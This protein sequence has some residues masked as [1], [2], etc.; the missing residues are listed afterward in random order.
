MWLVFNFRTIAEDGTGLI[1]LVLGIIFFIMVIARIKSIH[2]QYERPAI[3]LILFTAI[4]GAFLAIAG[5][6]FNVNQFKWI[7][8]LCV[9]WSC[10]C[11]SLPPNYYRDLLLAFFILYW[12]HPI[13]NR[14]FSPLQL[15]MQWLSVQGAEW[16]LHCFNVRAWANDFILYT[17]VSDFGVPEACSGMKTSVAVLYA[18]LGMGI[19][20]H[21]SLLAIL[22][23]L[24]I[25][26]FQ[27]LVLNIIRIS[28]I[29]FWSQRMPAG[30]GQKFIHDSSGIFLIISIFLIMGEIIWWHVLCKRKKEREEGIASG[31]RE[32]PEVAT[33]LPRMWYLFF[34]YL[35][36]IV[37]LFVVLIFIVFALYKKR[38]EHRA[39]MYSDVVAGLA[40]RDTKM[41]LSAIEAAIKL[42]PDNREFKDKKIQ[43]LLMQGKYAASLKELEKLARPLAP[44]ETVLMSRTL[45]ML[46]RTQEAIEMIKS[47]P[48]D[49]HKQPAVAM[50]MAE[51]GALQNDVQ[52]VCENIMLASSSHLFVDRIRA[53]FP[54][55]Q[56]HEQWQT[57]ADADIFNIPHKNPYSMAIVIRA[58]LK[59]GNFAKAARLLDAAFEKWP[60][61]PQFLGSLFMLALRQPGSRWE[62]KFAE[63]FQKNI[64]LLDR[65][66]L[67]TY[68]QELFRI[69]RPDLVWLAWTRLNKLDPSDPILSLAAARFANIWFSF[70]P[71]FLGLSSMD[72]EIVVDVSS[73]YR[74]TRN[75]RPFSFF[76]RLVP[77]AS[78][79]GK[80]D[81]LN[82]VSK[83]YLDKCLDS[84][85]VYKEK[86]MLTR[87]MEINVPTILAMSGKYD[88]AHRA[89]AE[90]MKKYPDENDELLLKKALL[91]EYQGKWQDCYEVLREYR[92]KSSVPSINTE[93]MMINALMNM[94][95]GASAMT[96][97][98]RAAKHFP[99]SSRIN[100]IIA[101]IWSNFGYW[102]EALF[103]MEKVKSTRKQSL[104]A[105]LLY[106]TQRYVEADKIARSSGIILPK[107]PEEKI[108]SYLP[109]PA[110]LTIARRWP[111]P[112]SDFE[113]KDRAK[114]SMD[115]SL[116][117][118]SPFLKR[119][120]NLECEWQRVEGKGK[121]SDIALWE[122][123]G[124]DDMEK[125][126][127]LNRLTIL[128]ASQ[129]Q[130][131]DAIKTAKRT[132]QLSPQT[133][134]YWWILI[135]LTEGDRAVVE[136]ARRNCPDDGEIW[137]ADI[138]SRYKTE[139]KGKWIDEEIE[140]VIKTECYPLATVVRAGNFLVNQGLINYASK[141]ARYVAD[142]RAR[143]YLPAYVLALHCALCVKDVKWAV[144]SALKCADYALNPSDFYKT[145]V[146]LKSLSQTMDAD[147]ISALEFLQ[148]KYPREKEWVE[149]LGYVYL[150]KGEGRRAEN[151]LSP[152]LEGGSEVSVRAFNMAAESARSQGNIEK[153]IKILETAHTLYPENMTVLN[154]LIYNLALSYETAPRAL[155]LLPEL[156]KM[157][158]EKYYEVMD[159]AAKVYLKN[160]RIDDAEIYI[161]KAL[162]NLP[163]AS[164]SYAPAEVLLNT[165]EILLRKGEGKEAEKFIN[166]AEK[167]ANKPLF[168]ENR[169][170]ELRK[171]IELSQK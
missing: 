154:N 79:I 118:T 149:R 22:V 142:E 94:N 7:G 63:Y 113:L 135:G 60:D 81:N 156:L 96:I 75:I 126:A 170:R 151:V 3:Y 99:G 83:R 157:A 106:N 107:N 97:A 92:N 144:P 16:L 136:E 51:Y 109:P 162:D 76:W 72:S 158:G 122:T 74:Q 15:T 52:M 159:T 108:Q 40:E 129:N 124:R 146:D 61:E 50:I 20:F 33:I 64:H 23:F 13:P 77:L 29:V 133:P 88:E 150:I 160:G 39:I 84:I 47:L 66:K 132:C 14:I 38:A 34:K 171:Q 100:E 28:S 62:W 53:L 58:Y 116:Q 5:F 98:Q 101:A 4:G 161:K 24:V 69:N 169:A 140:R 167:I 143:S 127:A 102:E 131:D 80:G 164:I 147:L 56:K 105:Q 42:V 25:A 30:W 153:S 110:E 165:A 163:S 57:I 59:V 32:K 91:Y 12:V 19:L 120:F 112:L 1:R 65:D 138:V 18:A 95:L 148:S 89:I 71:Q 70:R 37:L 134:V 141:I 137:L 155:E 123:I 90:L 86:G 111:K 8:I 45:F 145:I 125:A 10:F 44:S 119:L 17:P 93:I 104:M 27:V 73:L 48:P 35:K 55:L 49:L 87:Q 130:F 78:D 152:L 36:V 82:L 43:L 68:L 26:L 121:I 117:A 114:E 31:Q 103:V 6:I 54:F 166:E 115:R 46:G 21:F 11:W 128:Q 168:L 67:T 41:A 2:E 85:I 139:G 9:S